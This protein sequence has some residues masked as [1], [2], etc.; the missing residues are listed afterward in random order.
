MGR[1]CGRRFP[2][3]L[4]FFNEIVAYQELLGEVTLLASSSTR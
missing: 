2:S 1:S 4:W 3:N